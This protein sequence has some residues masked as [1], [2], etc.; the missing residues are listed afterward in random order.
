MSISIG[1]YHLEDQLIAINEEISSLGYGLVY[2]FTYENRALPHSSPYLSQCG[3]FRCNPA[4]EYGAE[5]SEWFFS[6]TEEIIMSARALL[7]HY[8]YIEEVKKVATTIDN[9]VMSNDQIYNDVDDAIRTHADDLGIDPD[10]I[11]WTISIKSTFED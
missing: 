3:R 5:Y 6:L 2:P 4:I 10:H 7:T 8:T 11:Q 9:I 1:Q